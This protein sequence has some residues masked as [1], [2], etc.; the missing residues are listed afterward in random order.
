M[1]GI[2]LKMNVELAERQAKEYLQ[3]A[4][5][6]MMDHGRL[7]GL[8]TNVRGAWQGDA[9]LMFANKL[10]TYRAQLGSDVMKIQNDAIAFGS[11]I[12]EVKAT[13]KQ[14]AADMAALAGSGTTP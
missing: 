7:E 2:E 8:I 10:E 11:K 13:D 5:D 3:I 1:F 12:E 9:S 14:L 4:E 6:L